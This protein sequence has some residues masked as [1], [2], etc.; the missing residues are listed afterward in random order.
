MLSFQMETFGI[1]LLCA[2]LPAGGNFIGSVLADNVQTPKW[3]VG[4]A[5]H[6]A[7]GV[8]IAV[9]GIDL[10]PRILPT[11]PTWVLAGTFVLGAAA[12]LGMAL[13]ARRIGGGRAWMV[14]VAVAADLT[15]DGLM[16]GVGAAV[17]SGLGLLIAISQSVANIPGGFAATASLEHDG[18]S[19]RARLWVAVLLATPAVISCGLGFWLLRD[20]SPAVQN[21][22][23]M[24]VAGLLL[25]ATIEDVVP[26][27]DASPRLPR[28][29]S[30]AA[31]AAGFVGLAVLSMYFR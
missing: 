11:T 23:L 16:A 14:C 29:V 3:I 24:V 30:T 4:A 21:A 8:A 26:E 2:L 10:M 25:V 28:W 15:S 6:G 12:A 7:A 1:L 31:F 17:S 5:L 9:V 13:L 27:G 20:A 22:A 19:R 18:V